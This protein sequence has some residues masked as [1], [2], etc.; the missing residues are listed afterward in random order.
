MPRRAAIADRKASRA[1]SH[2]LHDYYECAAR[3]RE[4]REDAEVRARGAGATGYVIDG[5]FPR[6]RVADIR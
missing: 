2:R 5:N 3:E 1:D 6:N 4:E